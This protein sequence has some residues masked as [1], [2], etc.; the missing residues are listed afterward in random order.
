MSDESFTKFSASDMH[1]MW[2]T[3][4]AE[5]GGNTLSTY[6]PDAEARPLRSWMDLMEQRLADEIAS[7]PTTWQAFLS[8][9]RRT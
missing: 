7:R 8:F 6:I 9:I 3:L 1:K 5:Q 4:K 2:R